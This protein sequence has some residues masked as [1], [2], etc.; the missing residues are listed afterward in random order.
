MTCWLWNF[1]LRKLRQPQT[2]S[3]DCHLTINSSK[4][5]NIL[6]AK[7]SNT[8]ING[9]GGRCNAENQEI[10]NFNA[11]LS[12]ILANN[13]SCVAIRWF[14]AWINQIISRFAH[15]NELNKLNLMHKWCPA[16]GHLRSSVKLII[17][18]EKFQPKYCVLKFAFQNF[19]QFKFKINFAN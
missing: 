6:R 10:S 2:L 12:R 18:R 1:K 16:W 4:N 14:T 11:R 7:R 5:I 8:K 3:V 9:F 17:Q 15:P 13:A 19:A